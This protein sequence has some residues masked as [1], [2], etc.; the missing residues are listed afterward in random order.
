MAVKL[1]KQTWIPGK[2]P[3]IIQTGTVVGP[4]EG[5]GPLAK[6][7][8]HVYTDPLAGERSFEHA[9]K[10]MMLN[11]CYTAL[12]KADRTPE[13]IDLFLAGDLLNQIITSGFAALA[14]KIP[15]LGLYGACSTSVESLV[16][17]TALIDA[18]FARSALCAVSS[19]NSTSERQYRYPTEY[20]L[21]R[22]P[23]AQ[24]TVTGAGAA[25]VADEGRGPRITRLTAGVVQDYG[26]KD[27]LNLGAA[28]APAAAATLA[29]HFADTGRDPGFYDLIVTG[30][31]G[32]FGR[33]LAIELAAERGGFDLTRNYQ[34]CGVM[35]Y[36]CE[37]QDVHSGGSGCACSAVVAYGYL[38]RRMLAGELRR[39]LLCATGALHSPTS[40]QQGENIPV[41]AH[42][43][44]L[45]MI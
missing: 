22:K 23:T 39:L 15:F 45:E 9:E 19:H 13:S 18:G 27:A 5:Q 30:D 32:K 3:A 33:Q 44:S 21:W 35:L 8:D 40:V 11:A 7:F 34:D 41:I 4:I 1:G 2:M 6:W 10:E 14:L 26:V 17:A 42:A 28:M 24:W 38:Y 12:K 36:D 29:Q 25:L 16:V 20:G 37:R 31:L 43:V